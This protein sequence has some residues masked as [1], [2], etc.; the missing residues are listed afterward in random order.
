VRELL[1]RDGRREQRRER[2]VGDRESVAGA[3]TRGCPGYLAPGVLAS[4]GPAIAEPLGNVHW[5]G[6]EQSVSYNTYAE[7]AVRSG[8]AVADRVLT[9]L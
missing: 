2:Q 3:W 1:R 5:A 4:F 6:A 8:E 7:G 9:E